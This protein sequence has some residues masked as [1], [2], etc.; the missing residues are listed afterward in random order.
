MKKVNKPKS[1]QERNNTH[2]KKP[3]YNVH[4]PEFEVEVGDKSTSTKWY[5]E[6]LTCGIA[7]GVLLSWTLILIDS[8]AI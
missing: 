6:S 5:S 2:K 4:D 1:I 8:P 7:K 3:P